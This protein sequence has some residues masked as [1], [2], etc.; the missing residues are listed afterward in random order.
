V[1]A[2]EKSLRK[3]IST[4]T[5]MKME[6]IKLEKF[7]LLKWDRRLKSITIHPLVQMAVKDEMSNA[8]SLRFEEMVVSLCDTTF[9]KDLSMET[10]HCGRLYVIQVRGPLMKLEHIRNETY[11]ST[12]EWVAHFL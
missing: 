2:F 4:E 10:V 7:S 12:M 11:V 6:L 5:Q 1:K 3:V 8:D 9:P